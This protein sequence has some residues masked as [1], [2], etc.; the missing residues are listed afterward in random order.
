MLFWSPEDANLSLSVLLGAVWGLIQAQEFPG[1][2]TDW[3]L[4]YLNVSLL[5]PVRTKLH[6]WLSWHVL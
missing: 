5:L 4:S 6:V 3:Q 2:W 1:S